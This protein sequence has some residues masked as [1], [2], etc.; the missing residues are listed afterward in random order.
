[1]SFKP[2]SNFTPSS[3]RI[4]FSCKKIG[5][6]ENSVYSRRS[7]HEGRPSKDII[8]LDKPRCGKRQVGISGMQKSQCYFVNYI[9]YVT[10]WIYFVNV[11]VCNEHVLQKYIFLVPNVIRRVAFYVLYNY[12]CTIIHLLFQKFLQFFLFLKEIY[13]YFFQLQQPLLINFAFILNPQFQN[14]YM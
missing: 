4:M 12:I 7:R 14:L 11:V 10:L 5:K 6:F 2:R 13:F 8:N 3:N 1:M 9:F